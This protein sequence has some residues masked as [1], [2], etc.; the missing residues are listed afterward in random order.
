M[1]KTWL[2]PRY[3][4]KITVTVEMTGKPPFASIL[5][6]FKGASDWGKGVFWQG[7]YLG[8]PGALTY[9]KA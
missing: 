1:L 9:F 5:M 8:M 3:Y 6:H 2:F 7:A 4:Y